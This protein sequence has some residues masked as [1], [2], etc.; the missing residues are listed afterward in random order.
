MINREYLNGLNEAQKDAVMHLDGPLLIVA[1][2]GSGKTKVLTSR[3]ANIIKEK[4]AFPNQ[5]LAVTFTNKAAKEMQ[6]RVSKILGS[7]AVGLSWLG[8]FHSICAKLLR[9]HASAAKLNSNFTII[10]TDDQIRLIKNICKAEN[11]DIKQLSPRFILAII[12]RWKNKGFYPGEVIINKKD[13]YEKTVLPLYKIYQQKLTD[14][15]SCDFGDLILHTVKILEFNQ[16]IREIYSKNF[17]YILVDEYQDTN[18]IQSKWL[19]L[20]SEKNKNICCV[21][22]DDQ[23]IYSWRGAE[24]KNFLEFDQVYENTKVIRLEQNYRSSQNILSVASNLISNNQNRVGKKLITTME[25]GDLVQLNCFKNGKD[26]AVGVSD[27]IEKKVK[28][29]FSYNNIAILVRAIFQTREFEERFL[30]IGMPYRILGGTKFY[31]RAEIK[32]CIAYLRLIHQEKDDLAFER[33]VNNPKRSIGDSTLKSIHEFAKENNLNLERASIKMLE[34]NLIKPKAKIGLGLFI[35]SLIKW[36]DDLIIKKSN[37][38]KLLQVVLDESGYSAMLKNKKDLDNEN[39]LENIKELLSA[40]KEF[41]NLE[42]FLEH[43]SLATSVDQEWDGEKINM[44][45]MHAAKGLEFD[46]VFLPGWEEGLFPH[47]K[48]IEEKGQNGLEEERRLAYVG[49]TRAKKKAIISFSMN[50]FYQGDWIDSMASRFIDEL[51]EKH[52][53]K[54]SFFEEEINNDDDFEFNQDFEIEEGTRSPG[55]IRYQKRIK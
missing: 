36:R 21:G 30:K 41:D 42:S 51:P 32:D 52:L 13:I 40:M 48:S 25:E 24:I 7:A 8:T 14:L 20:L 44:M 18:F 54:N 45:T 55:W 29:K 19:N 47:Q 31:E 2:A 46:V 28:K 1:G 34:Q 26:E 11:I 15:N 16:D 35:N 12:D 39:R 38:I 6:N 9:K 49:I 23:S 5:I 3:I 17:K 53:E 33:I 22:D 43:V 37:H 4:K 50:R 27:E 10:D